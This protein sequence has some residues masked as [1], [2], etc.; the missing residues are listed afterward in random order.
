MKLAIV[1]AFLGLALFL[2]QAAGATTLVQGHFG[3]KV[4]AGSSAVRAPFN[5]AS[6]GI[7]QGM[8]LSGSAVFDSDIVPASGLALV[9]FAALTDPS[10]AFE[11]NIGSL[12]FDLGT[13]TTGSAGITPAILFNDG[14]FAGLNYVSDFLYSDGLTYQLRFNSLNFTVRQVDPVTGFNSNSTINITG[15]LNLGGF[16]SESPY[17]EGTPGGPGVPEPSTWALMIVGLGG[18]GAMLRRRRAVAVTA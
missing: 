3:G 14:A 18:A 15:K 9:S 17:V 6:T 11:F 5:V 8:T 12:H 16:A 13:A 4:N 2:P 1:G 7:V 10:D